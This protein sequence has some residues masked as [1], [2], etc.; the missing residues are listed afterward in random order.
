MKF[1]SKAAVAAAVTVG[2]A[3]AAM[4][5]PAL[6]QKKNK[7]EEAAA[8]AAAANG[9]PQLKL[10]EPFRKQ[11]QVMQTAAAAGDAVALQAAVDAATPLATTDDEKYFLAAIQLPVVAKANDRA[12]LATLLDVLIAN[13]KTPPANVAQYNYL[14]GEFYAEQKKWGEALPYLTRARDLGHKTDDLTLRISQAHIE[15]GNVPAGIAELQRAVDAEV[16]AGRKPPEAWYNY[17]IARL[18]TSGDRAGATTWMKRAL[19]AY[20]T[21]QNWR[22]TIIIFRDNA[23]KGQAALTRP[24]KL[25]LFRLMRASNALADQNDYLEYAD[26]AFNA[27]VPAESMRVIDEGKAQ[28]KI[29]AANASAARIR[30]DAA[31]AVKLETPL[32]TLERQ[33]AA[34]A[35]GRTAAGTGDAYLANG[36]PAKAIPLY[37]LALQKGGVDAQQVNLRL[38]M[39]LALTGAKP[40]AKT[41]LAGVNQGANAD[42]AGLWA[43]WVDMSGTGAVAAATM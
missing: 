37:R 6:A 23:A 3:G 31:N 4:S 7:K 16:A 32:A 24:Q 27:G 33:A 43:Q 13:P 10:S 9:Q 25:D 20:P 15:A 21:P 17:G 2:L 18:Y 26:L 8:A 36:E 35:K 29:P 5:S 19:V 42:I 14:R 12:K 28:G 34:G 40:E 39:A 1:V 11:A 38:G 41:T 30:L 22:K